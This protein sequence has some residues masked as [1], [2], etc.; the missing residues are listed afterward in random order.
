MRV[1]YKG[2][3]YNTTIS[4]LNS[5]VSA[6]SFMSYTFGMLLFRS[7]LETKF[8]SSQIELEIVLLHLA[9]TR[10]ELR[11]FVTIFDKCDTK[12]K[13]LDYTFFIL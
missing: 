5:L 7:I 13:P 10:F 4:V 12:L 9:K 8:F 6:T 1:Y 2:L 11:S 3:E